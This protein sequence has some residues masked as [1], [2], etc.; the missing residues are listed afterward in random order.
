M[1][2]LFASC[3]SKD[4]S[5]YTVLNEVEL[6][7]DLKEISGLTYYKDGI[8]LAIQ[9]EDGDLFFL[10]EKTG[11]IVKKEKFGKKGDYEGVTLVG[12]EVYILRSDGNLYAYHLNSKET[13]KIKNTITKEYEFEGL[14]YESRTNR[15]ILTCKNAPK[16][17][18][19]KELLFFTYDLNT[20]EWIKDPVYKVKKKDITDLSYGNMD[21]IKPSGIMQ[22]PIN[23][24]IYVVASQG[25]SIVALDENFRVKY[26]IHILMH[27]IQPEGICMSSE[28]FPV[29]STEAIDGKPARMFTMKLKEDIPQSFFTEED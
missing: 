18:Q 28:G 13:K 6:N 8:L 29:I 17:L 22:N 26:V 1:A 15:L 12:N 14:F 10:D 24:E 19:K 25:K 11:E 27:S 7:S 23:N 2:S 20:N 3:D 4:N 16:K 21:D 9:D 5:W